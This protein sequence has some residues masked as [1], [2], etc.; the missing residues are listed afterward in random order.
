[1]YI[2]ENGEWYCDNC[3]YFGSYNDVKKHEE[4]VALGRKI[5][6]NFV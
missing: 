6:N 1:M 3:H 5:L 2:N 4:A